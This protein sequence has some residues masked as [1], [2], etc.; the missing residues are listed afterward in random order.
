MTTEHGRVLALLAGLL[1]AVSLVSSSGADGFRRTGHVTSPTR[2]EP[3]TIRA[4]FAERSFAPGE[5]AVLTVTSPV[6]AATLRIYHAGP[7]WARPK[8]SDVM[9]GV[10]AT[11]SRRIELGGSRRLVIPIGSWRSGFYFARVE[12]P[13]GHLGFAP[14]IVRPRVLG[15][16]RVAVVLPTN[17]WQAYNFRDVDRDGVGDTWYA[18][19]RIP[20]IDL[21]RPYLHRGVPARE[22]RGFLRWFEHGGRRAD[23]LS[24]DDLDRVESGDE[25][26]RLYD[27]VVFASHEEYVTEHVYDVVERYRDL[28]GNLAFLSANSFFYRVERRRGSLLC[29][30][31]LWNDLGRVD[32]RLTGVHFMGWYEHRYPRRPYTARATRTAPWF[33]EGTG[34][35]DGD[36][37]GARFGA[38]I[39]TVT[40]DS[41]AGVVVLADIRNIF[42]PGRTAT[43]AYYETSRGAKV[44]AAGAMGFESPQTPTHKQLLDNVWT[45]LARP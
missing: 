44:F 26:A 23:F 18:D 29:R 19:P 36:T 12:A 6:A 38:E 45:K 2:D 40:K 13:G 14:F 7:E 22:Y 9:L 10:P 28:G 8:T 42:G 5:R 37:F 1:V 21:S 27:L 39:D 32:A 41:P 30:T 20:C 16:A 4:F 34:L 15:A 33:F 17:T 25:L 43:M 35:R 24:D 11:S 31:G 3:R